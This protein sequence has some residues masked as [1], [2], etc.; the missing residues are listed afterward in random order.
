M[1]EAERQEL[2]ERTATAASKGE[3]ELYKTNDI[4]DA[5]SRNPQWL[6]E[7]FQA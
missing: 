5:T 3:Y 7:S 6:D 1:S 2:F 4:Y